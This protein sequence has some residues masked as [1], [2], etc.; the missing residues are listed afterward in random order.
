MTYNIQKGKYVI[1]KDSVYFALTM[2]QVLELNTLTDEI[3]YR[4]S[5][6][7]SREGE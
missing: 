2:D 7:S 1:C 3:I 5:I 6:S 4:E